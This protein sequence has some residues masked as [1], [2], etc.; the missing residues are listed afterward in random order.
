MVNVMYSSQKRDVVMIGVDLDS[1]RTHTYISLSFIPADLNQY[2]VNT[3]YTI[4]E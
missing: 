3:P 4:I 2:I 1:Q